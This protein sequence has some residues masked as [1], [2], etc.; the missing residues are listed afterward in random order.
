MEPDYLYKIVQCPNPPGRCLVFRT[1][2]NSPAWEEISKHD[3]ELLARRAI[4]SYKKAHEDL[5]AKNT[6][7]VLYDESQK[8]TNTIRP[9]DFPKVSGGYPWEIGIPLALLFFSALIFLYCIK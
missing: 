8:H 7:K 3:T 9:Q 1:H 6:Y 5:K 2:R 4:A